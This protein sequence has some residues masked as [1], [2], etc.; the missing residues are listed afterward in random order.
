MLGQG[1]PHNHRSGWFMAAASGN[2]TRSTTRRE[3]FNWISL[4]AEDPFRRALS[5]LGR[6]LPGAAR[7]L[8]VSCGTDDPQ[9]PTQS[10]RGPTGLSVPEIERRQR[11]SGTRVC[12]S[13]IN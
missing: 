11:L 5:G 6:H 9:F 12:D 13:F 10:N 1:G 3:D 2:I 7:E 8:P 4:K